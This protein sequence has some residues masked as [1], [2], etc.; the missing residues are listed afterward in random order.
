[1]LVRFSVENFRSFDQEA[2]LSMIATPSDVLSSHVMP[3]ET[4]AKPAGV[5]QAAALYGAN[6]SGKSNL[7]EAMN[8]AKRLILDGTRADRPIPRSPFKLNR[9]SLQA[10][11]TFRFEFVQDGTLYD[12]GFKLSDTEVLEEWL[13][14]TPKRRE[15]RFFERTTESQKV[16]VEIGAGLASK[17]ETKQ[18]DFLGFVAQGTR[19]NQLFL[20]EARDRNVESLRPAIDWFAHT[21]HI[22]RAEWRYKPMERRAHEDPAFSQF[23]GEFLSKAGT[24]VLTLETE[25]APFDLDALFPGLPAENRNQFVNS[26]D[27]RNTDIFAVSGAQEAVALSRVGSD[28]VQYRLWLKHEGG[29]GEHVR[30]DL[31]EE[32]EGTQRLMN[33]LPAL[34]DLSTSNA[35][36]VVDELDR[37][38]HPLLSRYFVESFFKLRPPGSKSQLIFTTHESNLLDLSLLR[39]DEI[40]FVEKDGKGAS[41]LSSLAEFKVRP[42]LHIQK[43]YLNGRFGAIPFLGDLDQLSS[44]DEPAAADQTQPA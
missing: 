19:P 7:V 27:D 21:L 1:M 8:F 33:L 14:A 9:T 28:A 38:L 2:T 34:A 37:R 17:N 44:G 32:S 42:D 31:S 29:N 30:F 5:V 40:W 20:T 11:S 18:R 22:I 13:F 16:S 36:Y 43:G 6:A 39:R 10:P 4:S 12:Y 26:L 35:V 41:H 25:A 23:A 3:M 24:G 15:V